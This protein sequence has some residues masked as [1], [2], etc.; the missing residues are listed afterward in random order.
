MVITPNFVQ[1]DTRFFLGIPS[2]ARF[3][4]SP[5]VETVTQHYWNADK[6]PIRTS[7]ENGEPRLLLVAVDVLDATS[8][9]TFDSYLYETRYDDGRKNIQNNKETK[10]EHILNYRDGITMQHVRASMSPNP[11]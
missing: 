1:L 4:N 8:A 9:V 11:H 2:F 6:E 5:L 10:N 7:F 3:S